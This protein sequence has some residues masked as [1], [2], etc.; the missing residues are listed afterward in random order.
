MSSVRVLIAASGSGGHLFPALH[1]ARAIRVQDDSA[2]ISFIGSGRPLE[3]KLIDGAG[4]PRY[5]VPLVGLKN[6][7][8][9]GLL[10]FLS[11][12]PG[13]LWRI[14]KLLGREKPSVIVGVGG[15][16]SVLPVVLGFMRGIPAWIHE[17]ELKPGL[18]TSVL[19]PFARRISKAF[20]QAVIPG[21]RKVVY[22]G[23]PVRPG[24]EGARVNLTT[25][26]SPN[27]V[28]VLGGSQGAAAIDRALMELAP[29]LKAAGLE[30]YHQTR[31]D[32][33]EV[34]ARS[35]RE[36][37]VPARVVSFIDEL[38]DAFT[39]CHLV[40]SRAGAGSVMEISVVGKPAI[41]VPYPHAQGDHQTANAKTLVEPGKALLVAEG[42][43]FTAR[44]K[45]AMEELLDRGNYER[46]IKSPYQ[47]RSLDAA[48]S[49]AGGIIELGRSGLG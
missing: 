26:L 38:V 12:L 40:V 35:Y 47:G 43:D 15:Y 4:F 29:W 20:P 2:A 24:L 45:A 8:W 27:R 44:L 14:W 46:M 42:A 22:T 3:S 21:G 5:E 48:S 19:W 6:R 32:L 13:A 30:M 31:P 17:A 7:G 37:G 18:A 23:H 11:L 28:L 9:R 41:F 16:V 34:V 33:T 36:A 25:T 10:Q 1:V 49:I 39:W